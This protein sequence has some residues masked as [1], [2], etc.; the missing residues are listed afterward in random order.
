SK[1]ILPSFVYDKRNLLIDGLSVRLTGNYNYQKAGSVDT[2]AYK[3]SW[4]GERRWMKDL[5]GQSNACGEASYGLWEYANT[6][7]SARANTSYRV[8]CNHS[9]SV[10]SV[11]SNYTRKPA[12]Q[13]AASALLPDLPTA[14][15]SLSRTR[16]TNT[17]GLEYRYTF[18]RKC[19]TNPFANHYPNS[20]SG[21]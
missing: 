1:S 9:M 13:R 3:Y 21:P 12:M 16:L 2:T 5:R 15:A 4:T 10:T 8:N 18:R 17:L 11:L 14:A 19:N 6:N 20:A 7:E